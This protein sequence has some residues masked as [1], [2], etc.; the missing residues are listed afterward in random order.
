MTAVSEAPQRDI[1]VPLAD[2]PPAA[3][4]AL[5]AVWSA[6]AVA[7][8]GRT[9]SVVALPWF[10]LQITGSG[11]QTG[12]AV[13]SSGLGIAAVGF[14]SGA[15]IDRSGAKRSSVASLV[16]AGS[17]IGLV[18]LLFMFDLL[19]LWQL[20]ALVF[21][22]SALDSVASVAV[23]ALV[24]DAARAA[25][26][27]LESANATLA[28][29]DRFA[30]LIM[31]VVAGAAIALV[32]ART[33]LWVDTVACLVAAALLAAVVPA[34]RRL[35]APVAAG[36]RG[37][38]ESLREGLRVLWDDRTLVALTLT[39]TGLNTLISG[40]YSIVLLAYAAEV[41]GDALHFAGMLAA[42]GGGALAGAVLFAAVGRRLPRRAWLL[43]SCF[44]TAGSVL[45]LA[46]IPGPAIT[47]ALL[48]GS[49]VL[50]APLGPLVAVAFQERTPATALGRVLSARNA[51]ML[52]GVP[53]GGLLA[54][55]ALDA[56]GLAG[57]VLLI[58]ALTLLV[59]V[60]V[61]FAPALRG[62]DPPPVPATTTAGTDADAGANPDAGV[63]CDA[64]AHSDAGTDAESGPGVGAAR[65]GVRR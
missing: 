31:P 19:A 60:A 53:L 61:T 22:A 43:V 54:G 28:A 47:M 26:V 39:G 8:I 40:L 13:A 10:V 64:G 51:L 2:A 1:G 21:V 30:L 59:A 23:E 48:A 49:G 37:Y 5:L 33:V 9:V 3:R 42:V 14:F 11:T 24:P 45:A 62:F 25:R 57:T 46:A 29:I 56:A 50:M 34:A 63:D 32:G 41:F 27:S 20:L 55:V 36:V 12:L 58:G 44:G 16:V 18:P 52:A 35:T 7:S 17:A 4:A 15:L 65:A 6:K 38:V